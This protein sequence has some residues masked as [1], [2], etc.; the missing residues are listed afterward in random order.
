MDYL[1]PLLQVLTA[2]VVQLSQ[3]IS[4]FCNIVFIDN[5]DDINTS[6]HYC[7]VWTAAWCSTCSCAL[8]PDLWQTAFTCNQPAV[9]STLRWNYLSALRRVL[10][11]LTPRMFPTLSTVLPEYQ[12]FGLFV[13]HLVDVVAFS[14][15]VGTSL[16]QSVLDW[17]SNNYHGCTGIWHT[18]DQVAETK[19]KAVR[20][21][22]TWI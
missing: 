4:V 12:S 3:L 6:T 15:C 17:M 14:W 9:R 2:L 10:G 22:L 7:M 20:Y 21:D 11:F 1:N 8:S 19:H 16:N 5:I 13:A 18:L